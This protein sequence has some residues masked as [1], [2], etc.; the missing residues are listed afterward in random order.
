MTSMP[1]SQPLPDPEELRQ[2]V[3][4]GDPMRAMPALAR[5]REVPDSETD[6][7]VVPL[8]ILGSEQEAFLV[9]SL[10]CSGLGVRRNEQGWEVLERLVAADEDANVRAE[11]ANAL[12]SY[13]IQRSWPLLRERFVADLGKRFPIEDKHD[14]EWILG[15]K[16]ERCRKARSLSLSQELYIQDLCKRHASLIDGLTKRLTLLPIQRCISLT[17]S[18]GSA[19]SVKPRSSALWSPSSVTIATAA[20]ARVVPSSARPAVRTPNAGRTSPAQAGRTAV[21]VHSLHSMM[22][23]SPA[24][25]VQICTPKSIPASNRAGCSGA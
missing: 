4:S 14:L 15:V 9:R 2:A 24:R 23:S 13:G 21:T 19:S 11:A 1:E 17:S 3:T 10:S 22:V 6:S 16:V 25:C 7:L 18:E 5:L 12:A 8:L 20:L